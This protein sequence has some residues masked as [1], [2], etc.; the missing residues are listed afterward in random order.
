MNLP[1]PSAGAPAREPTTIGGYVLAISKALQASGVDSTR[2]LK[3]AGVPLN[4]TN[5][6]MS[7][8][9]VSTL[10]RLFR[11]CADVTGSPYFGLTVARFIHISNLHALGYALAASADLHEFCHRL[12]RYFRLASQTSEIT[13]VESKEELALKIRTLVDLSPE[14]ED[15]FLGFLVL[16]MRQLYKPD[17]NPL[18]VSL[19][20]ALPREGAGPYEALFRAPVSFDQPG[21]MLVLPR[22][23]LHNPLIGACAE[24]AQLNDNLSNTYLARLEKDDVVTRVRQKIIEFLPN[25]I[26]TRDKIADALAMSPTTLQFKLAERQTS[27]QD[28]LDATRK[29]LSTGYVRQSSLSITEITFL[30]GFSDTSNFTRAFKRWQGV[31]P[32]AFREGARPTP[33]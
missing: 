21:P 11:A 19:S 32:T 22:A 10:T 24:L 18:R 27:F 33:P 30:L 8:L 14:T 29:E 4:M 6:P 25:G 5:D 28:L 31:S 13:V 2:V 1:L 12:E 16:A 9:P 3:A 15:A 23:D 20:H 7:R 26:C 17:F